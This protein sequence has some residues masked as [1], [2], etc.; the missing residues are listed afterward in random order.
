MNT[1]NFNSKLTTWRSQICEN[2]EPRE[3]LD[4]VGSYALSFPSQDN[5]EV[6]NLGCTGTIP[7]H[8]SLDLHQ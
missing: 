2:L 8:A 7:M 3:K 1:E 6:A 4:V 5:P